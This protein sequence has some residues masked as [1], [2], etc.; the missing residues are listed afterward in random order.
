MANYMMTSAEKARVTKGITFISEVSSVNLTLD[1]A[2]NLLCVETEEVTCNFIIPLNAT[3]AFP[4]G[5]EIHFFNGTNFA[6]DSYV[7]AVENVEL[8]SKSSY[9][10]IAVGGIATLKK[11]TADAWILYG[12]LITSA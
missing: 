7:T 6:A 10:H 8:F 1:H 11:I 4:I 9:T 5:T 2:E 12:D 3:V